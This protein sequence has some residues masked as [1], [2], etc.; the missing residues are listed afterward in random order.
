M[1]W[2]ET[3][4]RSIEEALEFALDQL[5]VD[6]ADAEYEVLE[7][8]KTGLFGRMRTEARVRARVRPTTPRQKDERR[9]RGRK[10]GGS[11]AA[12]P[13]AD[14]KKTK[15]EPEVTETESEPVPAA[16]AAERESSGSEVPMAD[17]G[18]VAASFVQGVL[19]RFGATDA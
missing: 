4:G 13:S 8:P 12:A 16:S 6:E 18:A 17:Q 15:R 19:D 5:G 2:V 3:T 10:A 9:G 14:R 1:E 7:E 11:K